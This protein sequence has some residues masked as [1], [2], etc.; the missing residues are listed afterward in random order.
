MRRTIVGSVTVVGALG[1][2]LA[3][4][5]LVGSLFHIFRPGVERQIEPL[6]TGMS[7][8]DEFEFDAGRVFA[9]QDMSREFLVRNPADDA[10][11]IASSEDVIKNCGC[12]D[13]IPRA[14][15][16][17]P[18]ESARVS[19][20]VRTGGK[21][22]PI[23]HGGHVDWSTPS[24]VKRVTTFALRAT[25]VPV[26]TAVPDSVSFDP[27]E[28]RTDAVKEFI[29]TAALPLDAA[30]IG[31]DCSP[32]VRVT[33]TQ[34]A[35][36]EW[37]CGVR[38]APADGLESVVGDVTVKARVVAH[39]VAL[40]GADVALR[41]A[42]LARRDVELSVQPQ[43]APVNFAADGRGAVRLLLRGAAVARGA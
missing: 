2:T 4:S 35:P 13:L 18:K 10:I 38:C 25:V 41:V 28:V 17:E 1:G 29:L 11:F 22:G 20:I 36:G 37:R 15:R 27:S 12:S 42:V 9:G 14:S 19:V 40:A 30:S 5:A 34:V 43:T 32:G 7:G 21:S 26:L 16:I 31:F 39:A 8:P 6:T 23:A 3:A 24:G 33:Q